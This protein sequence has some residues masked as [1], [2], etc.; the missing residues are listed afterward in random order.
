M[1]CR[2][3]KEKLKIKF[4]DLG[5]SPLANS[6]LNKIDLKKKEKFYPLKTWVCSN[7]LLVQSQGFNNNK[8]IFNSEYS[9]NS[10]VSVS[11]KNHF[12]KYVI[13]IIKFLKLNENSLIVEIGS[14]DGILLRN[15]GKLKKNCIGIEPS[16][17][18]AKKSEKY[19]IKV[20]KKFFNFNLT[21][22]IK[23]KANL[24]IANNVFAHIP[25]IN[26]TLKGLKNLLSRDGTINIEFPHLLNL[27][28]FKQFD[29]I[30]HEHFF[31]FS[32]NSIIKIFNRHGL[33]IW[34]I[35]KIN[36]H[37]GSLRIYAS[38]KERV[39]KTDKSVINILEEEKKFGITN[40][41]TYKNFQKIIE[42][43]KKEIR[44]FFNK[45]RILKQKICGFGAAAKSTTLINYCK[46]KNDEIMAMFDNS[47]N[48]YNKFIPGAKIPI[49]KPTKSRLKDYDI[50]IIFAWNIKKEIM[51]F[52]KKLIDKDT[53]IGLFIPKLKILKLKK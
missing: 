44:E 2:F 34:N 22:N 47:K 20:I 10:S 4:L 16:K 1:N 7:C 21:K 3:C 23:K 45:K 35:E 40:L 14:N 18:I 5:K 29:T 49:L 53:E 37:G 15:F 38:H 36:T 26:D 27:L 6:Y 12:R 11:L 41:N 32:L 48:K 9:Y 8:L 17:N 19:G 28:K 33:K 13:K 39:I 42:K 25:T 43:N 52:L 30:Y 51:F 46:I 50:I 31:Y 24:I